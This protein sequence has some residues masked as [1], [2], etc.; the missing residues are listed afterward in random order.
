MVRAETKIETGIMQ[1][2]GGNSSG[3]RGSGSVLVPRGGGEVWQCGRVRGWGA[4][5]GGGGVVVAGAS[6]GGGDGAVRGWRVSSFQSE[7]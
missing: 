5:G 1:E 4:G 7:L 6:G 3:G 2:D